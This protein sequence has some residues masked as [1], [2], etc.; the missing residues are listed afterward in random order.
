MFRKPLIGALGA[1]VVLFSTT[2][3]A[4]GTAGGR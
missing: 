4:Q 2:A 1:T 3:F